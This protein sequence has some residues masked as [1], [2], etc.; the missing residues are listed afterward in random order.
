VA[1]LAGPSTEPR[2]CGPNEI[3]GDATAGE[4]VGDVPDGLA[5]VAED[6]DGLALDAFA[7][8]RPE[9]A[10]FELAG[11]ELDA[12]AVDDMV[13]APASAPIPERFVAVLRTVG[14]T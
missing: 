13:Q 1:P 8:A 11:F 14:A 5:L 7:L 6:S 4:P 2:S 12:V 9:L 10:G 3:V